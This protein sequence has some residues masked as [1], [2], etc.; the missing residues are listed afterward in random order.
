M[1]QFAIILLLLFVAFGTLFAGGN[2]EEKA[3]AVETQKQAAVEAEPPIKIVYL[4]GNDLRE[5]G[6]EGVLARAIRLTQKKYPTL[7]VEHKMLNIGTGTTVSMDTLL[8]TNKAP[9]IYSDWMGRVSKYMV[10]EFTLPLDDI[11]DVSKFINVDELKRNGKLIAI[12]SSGN[13]QGMMVNLDL[14][15]K[16]GY[17]IPDNWTLDDFME[18]AKMVKAYSDRTGEEV[19]A[20]GLFAGNQSG[21]YLWMQWFSVF[22]VDLYNDDYSKSMEDEGGEEVWAFYKSLV[23]NGYAPANAAVLVDDDY[24]F[25]ACTGM[26]AATAFYEP[27]TAHYFKTFTEQGIIDGAFNYKFVPFPNNAPACGSNA[28]I[29]VNKNTE[30]PEVVAEILK[31]M[32]DAYTFNTSIKEG[33]SLT[34]RSDTT[35]E[36]DNPRINEISAAVVKNGMYDLGVSNPWFAEVRAEGYPV[37]QKVLTG[38]LTPAQAAE[39]YADIVNDII[40]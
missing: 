26:I 34:Y 37:L 18:M 7:E 22:G 19:Y 39:A 35:A 9:D 31:Y 24:L 8:A 29:I 1:K 6:K 30:Y 25:Q 4:G 17:P 3:P 40:Q 13:A 27:W 38:K 23:D 32:T 12:P 33:T 5:D 16:V 28:G 10:P 20:T 21:D 36:N 2:K 15:D 11:M 14:L